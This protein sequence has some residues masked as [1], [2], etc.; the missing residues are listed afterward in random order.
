MREKL[1]TMATL[2]LEGASLF[3][4][5]STRDLA[6]GKREPQKVQGNG[7]ISCNHFISCSASPAISPTALDDKPYFQW[8]DS[9]GTQ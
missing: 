1:M 2:V 9:S 5:S 6:T 3:N 4:S 8:S 7:R